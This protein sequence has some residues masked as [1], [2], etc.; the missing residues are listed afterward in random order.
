M[1]KKILFVSLFFTSSF[2][3]ANGLSSADQEALDK[4]VKLLTTQSERNEVIDNNPDAQK[5]DELVNQLSQ[6]GA[7]SEDVYALSAN[8][9]KDLL[10]EANGDSAVLQKLLMEAQKNPQALY[11]KLSP[12]NRNQLQAITQDIEKK[13]Q[14]APQK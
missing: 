1:D 8:I 10:R 7:N 4:T 14:T 12:E 5:A 6:Q 13:K 2:C 11:R 3:F 9:F